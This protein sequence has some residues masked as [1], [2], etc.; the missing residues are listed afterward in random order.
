MMQED[1]QVKNDLITTYAATLTARF[2]RVFM[3][4]AARFNLELIQYNAVNIF[5]HAKLDETVFMRMPDEHQRQ[6]CILKL[7]KTLYGLQ[8]SPIL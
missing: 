3:A 1:Q 8:K 4:L 5:V 6:G 7:N 2:F